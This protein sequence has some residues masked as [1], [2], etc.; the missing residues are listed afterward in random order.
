MIKL[1]ISYGKILNFVM[2]YWEK[3]VGFKLSQVSR[4]KTSI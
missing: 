2:K 4:I 1:S 3:W